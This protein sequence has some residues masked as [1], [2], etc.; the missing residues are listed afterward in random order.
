MTTTGL[1]TADF[2]AWLPLS[3]FILL[4]LMLVG[5][6]TGST[7]GGLKVSRFLLIAKVIDRE[8]RRMVEHRGVFAVRLGGDV[9]PERT[10]QS[11]LNL[12]YLALFIYFASALLLAAMG[13]DVL[14][15]ITAVAASMFNIGRGLGEVGPL[16]NYAGLPAGAKWVLSLSMIAGRLEYYTVLV[17]LTPAFW[18]K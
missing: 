5:G 6:C 2:E 1:V 7:A 16:D 15:T 13:V 14:T 18:R 9:I 11:L 8:F 17:I 3:Q 4:A 12:F 10:I